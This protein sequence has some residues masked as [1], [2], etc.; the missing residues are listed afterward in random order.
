MTPLSRR[1]RKR[2]SSTG[3]KPSPRPSTLRVPSW[4]Y[5]GSLACGPANVAESAA[6]T[7]LAASDTQVPSSTKYFV[8]GQ[9]AVPVEGSLSPY[10]LEAV[11]PEVHPVTICIQVEGNADTSAYIRACDDN[12]SLGKVRSIS[13]SPPLPLPSLLPSSSAIFT[14]HLHPNISPPPPPHRHLHLHLS[15]FAP[16]SLSS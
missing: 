9:D 6:S 5:H 7:N 13:P 14:L 8:Q 16:R 12:G 11:T 15:I 10:A 2:G 1:P 3:A 4:W